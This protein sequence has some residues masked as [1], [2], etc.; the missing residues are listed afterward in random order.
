[1]KRKKSRLNDFFSV[2]FLMSTMLVLSC[3]E[4]GGSEEEPTPDQEVSLE[5]NFVGTWDDNIYMSF[6]ISTI[7]SRNPSGG[8]TGPFFYSQNGSFTPC[9]N[10]AENNGSI[11]FT[12]E[13]DSIL[14]FRY[15]Q[16]LEFFMGGCPGLYTGKG[17]VTGNTLNISF[18][19]NDC[20]GEHTGGRIVLRK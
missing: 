19:G 12:I 13:G 14:D 9:C 20:E 7:L 17:I 2:L 3:S 5:G 11:S 1:M 8:Y 18:T 15:N 4:D 10:D 16:R 6:P